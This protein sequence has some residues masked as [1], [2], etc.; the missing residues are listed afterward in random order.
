MPRNGLAGARTSTPAACR[1]G[2]TPA[3]FEASAKAPCTSTTVRGA[4]PAVGVASVMVDP[5]GEVMMDG[6]TYDGA[7]C[8]VPRDIPRPAAVT[9]AAP[10]PASRLTAERRDRRPSGVAADR[11]RFIGFLPSVKRCRHGRG[12]EGMLR[13]CACLPR[14]TSGE[15]LDLE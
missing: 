12:P 11:V 9:R 10:A 1:M 3:Q 5:S 13:S 14:G 4:A 6:R 8:A 15:L 2:I 7:P